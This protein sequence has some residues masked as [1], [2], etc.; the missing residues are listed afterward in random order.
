MQNL[1]AMHAKNS[2]KTILRSAH[3][4]PRVPEM[5]S[6]P[7]FGQTAH[8]CCVCCLCCAEVCSGTGGLLV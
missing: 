2:L 7:H 1:I 5:S 8:N 3:L 6:N 4:F